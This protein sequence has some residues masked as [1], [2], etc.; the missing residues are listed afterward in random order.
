MPA[1]VCPVLDMATDGPPSPL[2]CNTPSGGSLASIL[3]GCV[4]MSET[5]SARGLDFHAVTLERSLCLRLF[6]TEVFHLLRTGA[7]QHALASTCI[8][9]Q[10]H[11][12]MFPKELLD[13]IGH[14]DP[15]RNALQRTLQLC[16]PRRQRLTCLRLSPVANPPIALRH[17][18]L[19]DLRV[20]TSP[21][22]SLPIQMRTGSS[23]FPRRNL[24]IPLG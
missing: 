21:A 15:F 17:P 11:L 20:D 1:P 7:E 13:R 24:N 8:C 19:H 5:R 22:Q 4:R 18:P 14:S 6:G 2:E 12:P 3:T 16:F 23:A 9:A 10:S